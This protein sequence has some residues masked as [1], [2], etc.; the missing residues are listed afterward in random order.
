MPAIIAAA[1]NTMTASN[2]LIMTALSVR[3]TYQIGRRKCQPGSGRR[4]AVAL[5]ALQQHRPDSG[6]HGVEGR[7]AIGPFLVGPERRHDHGGV[8]FEQH[9]VAG[10]VHREIDAAV[11]EV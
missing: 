5:R 10:S 3:L 11:I 2:S 1:I 9:Y 6:K 7:P 8:A 4:P